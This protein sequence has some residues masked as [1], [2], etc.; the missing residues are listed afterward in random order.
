MH[1]GPAQRLKVLKD[2]PD[3]RYAGFRS[4]HMHSV[5][6]QIDPHAER[7]F[8]Q[9]EVFVASPEQGLKVGRDLESNLQG[10]V[11]LQMGRYEAELDTVVPSALEDAKRASGCMDEIFCGDRLV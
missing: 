7:I 6:A 9:A 5:G 8:H 4:L 2:A 10:F 3:A 11:S 1:A